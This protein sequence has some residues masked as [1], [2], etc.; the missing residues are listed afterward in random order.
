MRQHPLFEH[1]TNLIH[2]ST[3]NKYL[4]KHLD[5]VFV[6]TEKIQALDCLIN[7]NAN[8]ENFILATMLVQIA[9]NTHDQIDKQMDDQDIKSKKEQQLTVLAGDYYSGIYYHILSQSSDISFI[10][11]LAEG[12]H[13]LTKLKTT[14][15]YQAYDRTDRFL[16]D[17][18]ALHSMIIKSVAAYFNRETH[19]DF[20]SKWLLAIKLERE[21][22]RLEQGDQTFFHQ[23]VQDKLL[24]QNTTK[25]LQ[26]LLKQMIHY[27]KRELSDYKNLLPE[28]L[29]PLTTFS[30]NTI[31]EEGLSK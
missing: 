9:L 12:I 17:Y 26:N 27:T 2:T 19:F 3:K 13:E 29:H 24:K 25:H 16:A 30:V 23:L 4:N 10:R 5:N 21:Y 1:Y 11:Q 22:S 15:F 8:K 20:V 7:N 14:V 28:Y 6:E 18:S 31:L